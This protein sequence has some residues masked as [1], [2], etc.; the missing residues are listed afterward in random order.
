M[1]AFLL[2]SPDVIADD[3][4]DDLVLINLRSGLYYRMAGRAR[5]ILLRHT[6]GAG[7]QFGST[8]DDDDLLKTESTD[9]DEVGFL[10]SLS[11]R[12]LL[13]SST[14]D[15]PSPELVQPRAIDSLPEDLRYEEF[16][17]LEDLLGLDPVHDVDPR[18]GW[19]VVN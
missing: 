2:N 14:S 4:G 3:A 16:G 6:D 12:G 10:E 15:I 19:P 9:A 1:K 7:L 18:E 17:D 13:I 11:E 8:Q 5:D